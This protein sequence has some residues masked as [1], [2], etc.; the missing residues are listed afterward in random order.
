ML[1]VAGP[2]VVGPAAVVSLPSD[3]VV[4]TRPVVAEDECVVDAAAVE[5]ALPSDG[6]G[7]PVQPAAGTRN[8]SVSSPR[9]ARRG[10]DG[11]RRTSSS[12]KVA[13][14]WSL[15]ESSPGRT[16]TRRPHAVYRSSGGSANGAAGP[17]C[18][19]GHERGRLPAPPNSSFFARRLS[20]SGERRPLEGTPRLLSGELCLDA[21]AC[22]AH[23][24]LKSGS[25]CRLISERRTAYTCHLAL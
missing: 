8:T 1:V 13:Y 14:A 11:L 17:R 2:V 19:P 4:D 23:R 20:H 9:A 6:S 24:P 16:S 22:S 3:V 25:C 18:S 12:L 10:S 15:P 7:A 21:L 5:D